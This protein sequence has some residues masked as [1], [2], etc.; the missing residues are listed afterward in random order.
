M[1]S[2]KKAALFVAAA[3]LSI[4][5]MAQ[6]KKDIVEVIAGSTNH[7]TLLAAVKAADLVATLQSKGP[8]TVFAPT[9]DAGAFKIVGYHLSCILNQRHH[10]IPLF[11]HG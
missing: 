5:A 1:K 9:N 10:F 2:I 4:N 6:T 8:F 11:I 3:L 7:T